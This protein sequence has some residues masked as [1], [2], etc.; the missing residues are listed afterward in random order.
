M[1]VN[2]YERI[3]PIYDQIDLAEIT[4]K[5]R[6]RPRLFAGLSGRILDA[7]VG[8]GRNMPFYPAGATVRVCAVRGFVLE[9]CPH[10]P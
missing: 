6:L 8:T 2:K 10:R 3:A 1:A 7:G 9:V 5:R 4:F